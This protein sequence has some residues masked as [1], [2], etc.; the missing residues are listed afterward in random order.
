L[1]VTNSA[2]SLL[3]ISAQYSLGCAYLLLSTFIVDQTFEDIGA[4]ISLLVG[5]LTVGS[6]ALDCCQPV[7]ESI[8]IAWGAALSFLA[9]H[10]IALNRRLILVH[11]VSDIGL[12]WDESH[13]SGIRFVPGNLIRFHGRF[14]SSKVMAKL[15]KSLVLSGGYMCYENP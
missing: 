11:F 15:Q 12:T 2:T 10:D 13:S 9:G 7:P 5:Q 6:P 1:N 14:Y 8:G 4:Y 3:M